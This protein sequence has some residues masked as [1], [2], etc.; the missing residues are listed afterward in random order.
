[1]PKTLLAFAAESDFISAVFDSISVEIAVIDSD[2]VIMIVNDAW[3]K[4]SIE[5]GLEPDRPVLHTAVGSNYLSVCQTSAA[6]DQ[7]S[8]QQAYQGIRAVLERRS[9]GFSLEYPCHS[10]K[11]RRWFKMEV[12]P[13]GAKGRGATGAVISHSNIT[14]FKL[15]EEALRLNEERWKFAIEGSRDG[16]WDVNLVSKEAVY[17]KRYQEILGYAEGEIRGTHDEWLERIH[18]NDKA[19]VNAAVQAYFDRIPD[20]YATEYRLRCK[21]GSYKWIYA[22]GMV[23]SW[24]ADGKPLRM[25]GTHTD[26]TERKK[27]EQTYQTLFQTVQQGVIYQSTDGRII[28]ANPAAEHILGMSVAQLQSLTSKDTIWEAFHEDGS[29]FPGETHPAMLAIKTGMPISGVVM[30]LINHQIQRRIWIRI[31]SIPIFKEGSD[32][33]DYVYSTFDD[34]TEQKQL[35]NELRESE[36]RFRNIANAAPLIIWTAD[37][38]KLCNWFSQGWLDFTGRD[39]EQELGNGWA[40]GLHP[41]DAQNCLH[42]YIEHFDQRLP[43]QIEYRL[44]H[45]SGEYRWIHDTGMPRFSENGDFMGY[46]GTCVDVSEAHHAQEALQKSQQMMNEAQHIAHLGSWDWNIADDLVDWSEEAAEIYVP[47]DKNTT[48]SFEAFK[49]TLH[50]E[51]FDMVIAAITAAIEQDVPYDIEHRVLSNSKGART[52]HC[53]GKVYRDANGKAIRL[54]GTVQDITD[55][56]L[57]EQAIRDTQEQLAEMT[58]AVPGVVYQFVR[59]PAGEWKFLY[60]S[61]GIEDLYEVTAE[62]AYRDHLVITRC[63]LPEDRVAHRE[64][65]ELSARNLT[66]WEYENRIKTPSGV[67]KWVHGRSSPQLQAD[68]SILWNGLLT[69]VTA[70]KKVEESL[71]L[72]ASV[73]AHAQESIM[74]TDAHCNLIDVN[75]GFTRVNGYSHDEVLGKNPRFLQ[76]GQHS[77]N[78]YQAMW[79]T[80]KEHGHWSGELWNRKKSGEIYAELLTISAVKNDRGIVSHYVGVSNDITHIKKHQQ[81]LEY[82]GHHDALTGLPNRILLADRM[83]QAI[84]HAKRE[85]ELLVVC[86]LDLDGFK[87]INDTMGHKAGDL[88][89]IE[90]ARRISETLRGED[91]VARLGG[92]EFVILLLGLN[93]I[94]EYM[95]TLDR[96]LIAISNPL[97]INNQSCTVGASIGVS[98]FPNNSKDQDTLLRQADQAMYAA[99]QSGKNCYQLYLKT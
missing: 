35:E 12:T 89:L 53:Q 64:S 36:Q 27:T 21:D 43:F 74:I 97:L 99:K 8:G 90:I 98:I 10:P 83:Q 93:K 40:E 94:E 15:I 55:R 80:V 42:H 26:I 24:T 66:I 49:K 95:A 72:A 38:N 37:I 96:L 57:A 84:A 86:Y 47:D 88:V 73:F 62:E 71:R 18:P 81:E 28:S 14:E 50:P 78:F 11:Q 63:I 85:K 30:G 13:F 5:N 6:I 3:C 9:A 45:R 75:A 33:V 31:T 59:T 56:L 82:I 58:A 48:P 22:R 44:K 4:F 1:M 79:R 67:F 60:L 65:V 20:V 32:E 25:V 16:V 2:G 77:S 19:N 23:V 34:I 7:D 87:P 68:G 17:S 92:D 61:K 29:E 39:L 91:T 69:D 76:S 41:D 70:Q 54:V 52:V 46:I 51:D